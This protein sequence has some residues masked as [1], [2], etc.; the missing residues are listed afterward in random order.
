MGGHRGSGSRRDDEARRV[1][2]GEWLRID[3][4]TR[5]DET[6]SSQIGAAAPAHEDTQPRRGY[7]GGGATPRAGRIGAEVVEWCALR[8]P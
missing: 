1:C 7:S 8:P 5:P 6:K 2:E 3:E 4:H